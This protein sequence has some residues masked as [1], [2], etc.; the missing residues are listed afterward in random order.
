MASTRKILAV[1]APV[2]FQS[3]AHELDEFDSERTLDVLNSYLIA[4][5]SGLYID[6]FIVAALVEQFPREI[7][8]FAALYND[9]K[10]NY[11]VNY[12][13]NIKTAAKNFV[14]EMRRRQA[15]WAKLHIEETGVLVYSFDNRLSPDH[16][17]YNKLGA[18]L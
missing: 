7:V 4:K 15:R 5:E 9:N 13:G 6:N 18:E 12:S 8:P 14:D 17:F 10:N 1:K 2:W 3:N 11:Q 16:R